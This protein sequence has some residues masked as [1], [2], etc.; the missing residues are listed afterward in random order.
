MVEFVFIGVHRCASAFISGQ[1][2]LLCVLCASAVN[3]LASTFPPTP[4]INLS[5]TS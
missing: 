2:S 4:G 1:K 5:S 3:R